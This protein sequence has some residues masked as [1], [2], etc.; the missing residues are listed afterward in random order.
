MRVASQFAERFKNSDL[1]KLGNIEKM[2]K[3]GGDRA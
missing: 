2:S 1:R 3:L